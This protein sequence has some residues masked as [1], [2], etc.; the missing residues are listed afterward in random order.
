MDAQHDSYGTIA[1]YYDRVIEPLNAPLG[2][3]GLSFHPI[4][5]GDSVLDVGCGTGVHLEAYAQAGARCHGVDLSAAMLE[6]AENR[7]GDAAELTLASA[8]HLPHPDAA[9]DLVVASLFLHELDA[10]TRRKVL[11]EMARVVRPDGRLL[12]IDYRVGDL[13][14]KGRMWRGTTT[15]IERLA[16]SEHF[17]EWRRYLASGGLP[18]NLPSGLGIEKEKIV[19]G[20]NLALWL[21]KQG[22]PPAQTP[23][24]RDGG[25]EA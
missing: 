12:V 8:T 6:V 16:G 11:D 23:S 21:V 19:A 20:G 17:R 9:F 25:S 24:A 2:K 4:G 1:K 15:V 3:A 22:P 10:D 14:L 18:A 5:E 7:L 13:R